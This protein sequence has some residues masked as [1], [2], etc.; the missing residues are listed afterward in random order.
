MFEG[1]ALAQAAN[2]ALAHKSERSKVSDLNRSHLRRSRL[3][4]KKSPITV[5]LQKCNLT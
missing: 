2:G 4:L 3:P 1:F 5:A